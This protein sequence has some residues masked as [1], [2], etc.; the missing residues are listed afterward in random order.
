[1]LYICCKRRHC[2]C[3]SDFCKF[4][5]LKGGELFK[6]CLYFFNKFGV[7]NFKYNIFTLTGIFV[8]LC[9]H[10]VWLSRWNVCLFLWVCLFVFFKWSHRFSLGL[11]SWLKVP[12]YFYLTLFLFCT[13]HVFVFIFG[14]LLTIHSTITWKLFSFLFSIPLRIFK[15]MYT[16][17]MWTPTRYAVLIEEPRLGDIY[18]NESHK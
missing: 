11:L 10:H 4:V 16:R 15:Y 8:R 1:M 6:R 3:R 18:I 7:H 5:R 13:R 2:P 12:D 17:H 14:R 9:S